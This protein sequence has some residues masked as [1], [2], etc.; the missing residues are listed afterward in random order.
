MTVNKFS[1]FHRRVNTRRRLIEIREK[2]YQLKILKPDQPLNGT[3]YRS[4]CNIQDSFRLFVKR[5]IFNFRY[6]TISVLKIIIDKYPNKVNFFIG[7]L[8]PICKRIQLKNVN[9]RSSSR[10]IFK[11]LSFVT[12]IY[13]G[14]V[15]FWYENQ[16][17]K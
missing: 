9:S 6:F 14:R 17:R 7:H 8:I 12:T 15:N 4:S 5:T 2:H 11:A 13:Q 16:Q 3:L 1:F 10:C